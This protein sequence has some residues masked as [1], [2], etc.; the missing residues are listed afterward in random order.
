MA[1]EKIVFEAKNRKPYPKLKK[2]LQ[3]KMFG[4]KLLKLDGYSEYYYDKVS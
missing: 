4:R 2:E 3:P 1:K